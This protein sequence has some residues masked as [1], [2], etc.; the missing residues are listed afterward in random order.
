MLTFSRIIF[1]AVILLLAF[2]SLKHVWTR[3]V[4]IFAWFKKQAESIP[5]NPQA[6]ISE[7]R[8]NIKI[9]NRYETEGNIFTISVQTGNNQ[10]FISP[11]IIKF[12]LHGTVKEVRPGYT[13]NSE[14]CKVHIGNAFSVNNRVIAH[15][16]RLTFDQLTS[17]VLNNTIVH[18]SKAKKKSFKLDD[19]IYVEWYWSY[20]GETHKE[21]K[22]LERNYKNKNFIYI[23]I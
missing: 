10:E 13:F 4:D 20:K 3:Q 17:D 18:F 2:F 6:E 19:R 23:K 15:S 5:V 11:L 7:K 21:S 12:K 1:S 14:P 22:W 16:V 9:G 8:P